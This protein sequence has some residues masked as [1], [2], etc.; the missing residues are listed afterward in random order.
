MSQVTEQEMGTL[1]SIVSRADAEQ[2]KRLRDA[3][4]HRSIIV[5]SA[6]IRQ[7]KV[8]SRVKWTDKVGPQTGTVVKVKHKYVEVRADAAPGTIGMVWNVPG[9]MLT[10]IP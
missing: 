4:N 10:V 2:L 5:G 7:I 1:L 3:T 8:N 6:T 9:S